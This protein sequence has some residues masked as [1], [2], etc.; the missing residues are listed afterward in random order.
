MNFRETVLKYFPEEGPAIL[1]TLPDDDP[2][3]LDEM[4][5]LS[6]SKS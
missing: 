1:D 3:D 2:E 6:Q 4:V 5:R